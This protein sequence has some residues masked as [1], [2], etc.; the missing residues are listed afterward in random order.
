LIRVLQDN[1][2]KQYRLQAGSLKRILPD[3]L[4]KKWNW[5]QQKQKEYITHLPKN[6]NS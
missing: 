4:N 6:S 3:F 5:P 1:V 2:E